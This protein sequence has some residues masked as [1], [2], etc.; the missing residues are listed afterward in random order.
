V[1]NREF[2]KTLGSV[3]WRPTIFPLPAFAARLVLGEMADELLLAS[4]RVK[5][6]RLL[7]TDYEFRFPHLEGALRHV[8]DRP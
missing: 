1:T 7:A 3:L 5:P 2:T 6:T 4:T 8:L